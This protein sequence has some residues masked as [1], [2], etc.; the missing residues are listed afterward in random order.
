MLTRWA[1]QWLASIRG[2]VASVRRAFAP[3]LGKALASTL[4][5]ALAFMAVWFNGR[6]ESIT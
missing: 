3:H 5:V 1:S 6:L 2:A 4:V